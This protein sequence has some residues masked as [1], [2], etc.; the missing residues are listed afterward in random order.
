LET[1]P[2]TLQNP[3]KEFETLIRTHFKQKSNNILAS[4]Q[5]YLNGMKQESEKEEKGNSELFL[6]NPSVGFIKA[7]QKL[8]LKLQI[9][10]S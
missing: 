10:L 9:C 2:V 5:K 7:L 6:K 4:C 1:I 8:Y 3:A